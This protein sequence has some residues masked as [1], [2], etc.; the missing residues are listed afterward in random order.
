M[1]SRVCSRN[2]KKAVNHGYDNICQQWYHYNILCITTSRVHIKGD[3]LHKE[4][5]VPIIYYVIN[6]TSNK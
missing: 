5:N 6:I 3:D 4:I 2:Y 1:N